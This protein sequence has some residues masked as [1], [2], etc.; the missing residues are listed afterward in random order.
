MKPFTIDECWTLA[1]LYLLIG[2]VIHLSIGIIGTGILLLAG[3]FRRRSVFHAVVGLWIFLCTL[4]LAGCL[5]NW[6]WNVSIFNNLYWSHDYAGWDCSP[7]WLLI[8]G[9]HGSPPQFFHLTTP[10]TIRLLWLV[11]AALSWGTAVLVT[12]GIMKR[13]RIQIKSPPP[14]SHASPQVAQGKASN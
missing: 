4:L 5:W 14:P 6:I 10:R 7:F 9:E 3:H 11:Y 12:Y 1:A 13:M 8:H 2:G